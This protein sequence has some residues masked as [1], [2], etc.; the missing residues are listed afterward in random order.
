VPGPSQGA[1]SNLR[2]WPFLILA[3]AAAAVFL[4]GGRHGPATGP[5]SMVW[6]LVLT[7]GFAV[8]VF[9][10]V[11]ARA[12]VNRQRLAG[13]FDASPEAARAILDATAGLTRIVSVAISLFMSLV[14]VPQ[15][16]FPGLGSGRALGLGMAGILG[17]IAWSVWSLKSVHRRL[18]KT[19]Q[20]G[21]LE[22]WNG[23][24]YSNPK[25]SRL[26]VPKLSGLGTTL[27]FAHAR[28][29]LILGAILALSLGAA[30]IGLVAPFS[31]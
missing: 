17:A 2:W 13:G 14:V 31:R 22:G 4:S 3:G 29:W 24:V 6:L 5:L 21:G 20:L 12:C 26:W 30:A 11:A 10:E 9:L 16:L 23:F 18:E 25:D 28:S 27:N 7:T 19:G 15:A 8:A 1:L